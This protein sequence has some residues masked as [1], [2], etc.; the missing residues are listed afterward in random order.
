MF[1]GHSEFVQSSKNV[2]CRPRTSRRVSIF[3]I[4]VRFRTKSSPSHVHTHSWRY[5]SLMFDLTWI[6][7]P[8]KKQDRNSKSISKSSLVRTS[9]SSHTWLRKSKSSPS[10]VNVITGLNK[11]MYPTLGLSQKKNYRRG[12]GGGEKILV[13]VVHRHAENTIFCQMGSASCEPLVDNC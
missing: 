1:S 10:Q 9:V 8:S 3:N 12:G 4:F 6:S 5:I 11:R 7:D 2:L 13:G